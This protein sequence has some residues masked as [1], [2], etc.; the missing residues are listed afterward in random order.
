MLKI[1]RSGNVRSWHQFSVAVSVRE[2]R[3]SV[4]PP[5]MQNVEPG[6]MQGLHSYAN[7]IYFSTVFV[8]FRGFSLVA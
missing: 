3:R 1:T 2:E 8:C 4:A 5:S 6:M 7:W